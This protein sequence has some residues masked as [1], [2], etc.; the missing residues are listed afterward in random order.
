MGTSN[1]SLD[2]CTSFFFF[3]LFNVK[4][5]KTTT[6]V[7]VTYHV[8]LDSARSDLS[9]K[10]RLVLLGKSQQKLSKVYESIHHLFT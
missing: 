2:T 1:G 6:S 3:S 7:T 9:S 5:K 8:V 4:K 10:S